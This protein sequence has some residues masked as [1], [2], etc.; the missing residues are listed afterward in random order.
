[1]MMTSKLVSAIEKPRALPALYV[2]IAAALVAGRCLIGDRMESTV[3]AEPFENA[4]ADVEEAAVQGDMAGVDRI[5]DPRK[6][7]QVVERQA[8]RLVLANV[9]ARL[10]R[11]LH[12]ALPRR[13]G[14]THPLA[15]EVRRLDRRAVQERFDAAAHGVAEH[16][17]LADRKRPHRELDGRADPVRLVVG[18]VRRGDVGD[19]ADDEQLARP[20]VEHHLRVGA[21]VRAGDDQ[22]AGTLAEAAQRFEAFALGLP[23]TGTEAAIAFDQV[24]HREAECLFFARFIPTRYNSKQEGCLPSWPSSSSTAPSACAAPR[25]S[26]LR[27]STGPAA[28]SSP[29]LGARRRCWSSASRTATP[30]TLWCS[31]APASTR[32]KSKARS[33]P[34]PT[35]RWQ[36]QASASPSEPARQNPT[37]PRPRRSSARCSRSNRSPTASRP[38]VAPVA[39]ISPSCSSAWASPKR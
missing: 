18:A 11:R 27:S 35:P 34:A 7:H 22:R 24:V 9:L 15:D 4:G 28:T 13:L 21:A 6:R 38:P 20:G 30:L 26:S 32:C 36:A 25:N 3:R 17:D 10:R 37:F 29:L 14:D 31:A 8:D 19:V 2:A 1:M 33:R 16:D 39:F 12:G 5:P 23:G